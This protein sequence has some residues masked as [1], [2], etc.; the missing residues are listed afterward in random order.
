MYFVIE[1]QSNKDNTAAVLTEKYATRPEAESKFHDV[2][3]YAAVSSVW[4]HSATMLSED[5]GLL[6]S[7]CY[8]HE[9][10]A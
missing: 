7:D 4:K 2:L 8:T 3:R 5:G 9:V 6:R 1:I 10:E